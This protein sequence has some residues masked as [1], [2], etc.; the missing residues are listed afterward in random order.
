VEKHEPVGKFRPDVPPELEAIIDKMTAKLPLQRFQSAKEVAEK[1]RAWLHESESGRTSYSRISALMA[2]AARAKQSSANGTAPAT[3]KAKEPPAEFEFANL[4]DARSASSSA[5][6]TKSGKL[7]EAKAV[8]ATAEAKD[9]NRPSAVRKAVPLV[10]KK[11]PTKMAKSPSGRL[12]PDDLISAL[13]L[14][15]ALPPASGSLPH[16]GQRPRKATKLQGLLKSPWTWV[17]VGG[18]VTLALLL[19]LVFLLTSSSPERTAEA[20]EPSERLAPG[21]GQT[22][23]VLPPQPPPLAPLPPSPT[24]VNPPAPPATTPPQATA[25]GGTGKPA[26]S[27]PSPGEPSVERLLAGLTE[28]DVGTSLKSINPSLVRFYTP[29]GSAA[30]AAVGQLGLRVTDKAPAELAVDMQADETSASPNVRLLLELTY[31]L[32]DG[33]HITLWKGDKQILAA[34]LSSINTLNEG[35][36]KAKAAKNTAALFKELVNAVLQARAKIG[37]K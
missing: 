15:G 28:I 20:P 32:P 8:P 25:A 29:V 5:V 24:A 9:P 26:P 30:L 33:K 10:A 1:L 4:D 19:L 35:P 23:S 13:P 18:A 27:P 22:S 16:M 6:S 34:D 12:L 21:A 14:P 11:L 36:Y 2:E 37:A 3:G 7:A 31:R 17:G